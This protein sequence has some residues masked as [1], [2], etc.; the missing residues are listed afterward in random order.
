MENH[1]V[2]GGGTFKASAKGADLGHL[3]QYLLGDICNIFLVNASKLMSMHETEQ[4]VESW[5]ITRP[6]NRQGRVEMGVG[7]LWFGFWGLLVQV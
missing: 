2:I 4:G 6:A 1:S 3:Y 7:L 5:L